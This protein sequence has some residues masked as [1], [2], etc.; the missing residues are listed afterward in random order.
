MADSTLLRETDIVNSD[1][2]I[3]FFE[4]V[5]LLQPL[6]ASGSHMVISSNLAGDLTIE[7]RITLLHPTNLRESE[8]VQVA[9][10]D[11]ATGRLGILR[12][13]ENT[14]ARSWPSG[15]K[16]VN[17]LTAGQTNQVFAGAPGGSFA[18][19]NYIKT[20]RLQERSVIDWNANPLNANKQA[21]IPLS[22][23]ESGAELV[24]TT[25]LATTL[26]D[27]V[28]ESSLSG[29]LSAY[30][31]NS[32]L[33]AT[34]N[35]YSTSA[36][37]N[38]A[39]EEAVSHITENNWDRVYPSSG[40]HN[41]NIGPNFSNSG[42]IIDLQAISDK[43]FEFFIKITGV[44]TRHIISGA[45]LANSHVLNSTQQNGPPSALANNNNVIAFPITYSKS[46]NTET[47]MG[48]LVQVSG[49]S[50]LI[51]LATS[52]SGDAVSVSFKLYQRNRAGDM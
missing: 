34:L 48:A 22:V 44:T 38:T 9:T 19:L 35:N 16:M 3:N 32:E 42:A 50:H 51:Y 31:L 46:G 29:S 20:I 41:F 37:M 27:Y 4:D 11:A 47:V 24:T 17:A 18:G 5:E 1:D 30:V 52:A 45:D 21:T 39:I 26:G 40:D 36:Q 49:N 7:A 14:Q 43:E 25:A 23:I 33:T 6:S 10:I 15:T 2:A 8:I 12:G 28:T 13:R